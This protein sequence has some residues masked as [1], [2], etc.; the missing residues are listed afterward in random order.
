MNELKAVVSVRSIER[1]LVR[2]TSISVAMVTNY[3]KSIFFPFLYRY[4]HGWT[5]VACVSYSQFT[6]FVGG[7]T[8]MRTHTNRKTSKQV[9]LDICCPRVFL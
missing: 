2:I 9:L 8:K 6:S 1:L 7:W 3:D 4:E 5:A